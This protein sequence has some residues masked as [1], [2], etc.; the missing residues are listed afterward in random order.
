MNLS[1]AREESQ[2]ISPV[3][4]GNFR[5]TKGHRFRDRLPESGWSIAHGD[6]IL[7]AFGLDHRRLAKLR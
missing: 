6:R 4:L 2:D 3:L 5:K 1:L 7:P